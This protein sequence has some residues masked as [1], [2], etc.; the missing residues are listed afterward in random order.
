MSR[1]SQRSRKQRGSDSEKEQNPELEGSDRESA[2]AGDEDIDDIFGF[3]GDSDEVEASEEE[4]DAEEDSPR[5]QARL[6]ITEPPADYDMSISTPGVGKGTDPV[7][8]YLREMGGVSLL[9]REGEV[10]IAKRIEEGQH[11]VQYE[12][13]RS[14]V[15]LTYVIE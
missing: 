2:D 15:A 9:T 12:V 8:M 4:S 10:V 7:R 1:N 11:E 14:P 3:L 13:G 6:R 5:T